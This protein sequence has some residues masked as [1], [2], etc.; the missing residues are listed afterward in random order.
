[1]R[2][3]FSFRS[4]LLWLAG[5][6]LLAGCASV[7]PQAVK[8]LSE[9]D[10]EDR[11]LTGTVPEPVAAGDEIPALATSDVYL[12]PPQQAEPL[13]LYTVTASDVPVREL[14]F[15][16]ARDARLELDI[17]D[18]VQ[19]N[20][21]INAIDQT[22]PKILKR[23][24]DQT[25]LVFELLDTHLVVRQDK[26][27]W[28]TYEIDYLNVQREVDSN[29]VLNMAV[30]SGPSGDDSGNAT[31]SQTQV[32]TK[33]QTD[34][35]K[36]MTQN[37]LSLVASAKAERNKQAAAMAEPVAA[38]PVAES[39]AST[40]DA[41]TTDDMVVNKEA[42]VVSVYADS[43]T[44]EQIQAY[45][46]RVMYRV[47]KEVLIEA[48]IVEV[49]LYD[50]F[51]SGVDWTAIS[52]SGKL[53]LNQSLIGNNFSDVSSGV[54][55]TVLSPDGLNSATAPGN[56]GT[57]GFFGGGDLSFSLEWI[58]RYGDTKVLSSPKIM[59]INNQ[60]AL[61]KV[62]DNFV[63]FGLEVERDEGTDGEPDTITFSSELRTVPVGLIM[64]V[65][66]FISSTDE[67][68]LSVRPTISRI[69]G[70]V[71]DPAVALTAA[72][73]SNAGDITSEVPIIREREMEAVLKVRDGQVAVIG[74]LMQDTDENLRDGIP[75]VE[76]TPLLGNAFAFQ[77]KDR[78]KSELVIFIR[79]LIVENPD[80]EGGDL[81]GFQQYLPA[82]SAGKTLK[83]AQEGQAPGGGHL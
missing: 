50:E 82:R 21:T 75:G 70:F 61:L 17:Y 76:K 10:L 25:G 3:Q 38:A 23:I 31:S 73:L 48:T 74:G 83:T 65:T 79:P 32:T 27:Y 19:G 53:K 77:G 12:P 56:A 68:T 37:I 22:L 20:V 59:A 15:S 9:R 46:D 72:S 43:K 60:T 47:K 16:L 54:I 49:E 78:R 62:V 64:S 80:V 8:P 51:K 71:E 11:H 1:M 33:S 30:S 39:I 26:P 5:S 42:G 55:G 57:A 44:Q 34:F 35:W 69:I 81:K 66:P 28:R 24:T 40:Q 63:Y 18:G 29:V 67:V 52:R 13:E 36:T 4:L 41:E 6:I 14:L 58:Q 2:T 45:L 7:E